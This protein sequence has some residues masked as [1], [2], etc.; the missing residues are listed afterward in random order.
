MSPTAEVA[1]LVAFVTA[2]LD[3]DERIAGDEQRRREEW[4]HQLAAEIA[5]GNVPSMAF[6]EYDE[7]GNP[8]DPA[9][10]LADV[11]A[12]RGLLA[13]L[14]PD[15]HTASGLIEPDAIGRALSTELRAH[16]VVRWM[17]ASW[18]DHPDFRPGWAPAP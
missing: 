13:A 12:K 11:A 14:Q 9:R 5:A 18:A 2:R 1:A 16:A 6:L 4:R 10:V 7:P 8:G 17:A 3:E 15:L